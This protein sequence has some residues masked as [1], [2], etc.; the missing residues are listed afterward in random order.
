VLPDADPAQ[1]EGVHVLLPQ[2]VLEEL[3]VKGGGAG[4][5]DD[6][7]KPVLLYAF[8]YHVLARFGAHEG[9]VFRNGNVGILLEILA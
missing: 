7:V 8:R 2:E 3:S 6:A 5:D 9:I 4:G 1:Q